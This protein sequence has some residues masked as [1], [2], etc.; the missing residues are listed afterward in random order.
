MNGVRSTF[1]RKGYLLT[2]LAAAALLAASPGTAVA[3]TTGVTIMGPAMDTINE[4]GTA[5]YTVSISGYVGVATNDNDPMTTDVNDPAA[6][7]VV[8]G[9]PTAAGTAPATATAGELADLNSNLHVLTVSFDPPANSSYTNRRLFTASQTISVVTL[10]D[11][12]AEN[13]AFDI[14]F[15]PLTGVAQVFTTA[16]T[17]TS[18]PISLPAN[19]PTALIIDDDETQTYTLSLAPNAMPTEG[20][21]L[22][23]TGTAVPAHTSQGSS[24]TLSVYTDPSD[25]YTLTPDPATLTIDGNDP[26][27]TFTITQDLGDENRVADTVTVSAYRT[28]PGP[29]ADTLV[30]SLPITFADANALPAVTVEF[31]N[32]NGSIVLDPQPTSVAEGESVHVRATAV[33]AMGNATAPA[34][35]LTIQLRAGASGTADARDIVAPGALTIGTDATNSTSATQSNVVELTIFGP[36]DDVGDEMLV[37][38]AIV[39]GVATNG[40]ET[41]TSSS[42][43]TLTITDN[44]AKQ[45][46]PKATDVAYP[47]ITGA[48]EDGAGDGGLNPGEMVEIMTDELFDVMEGYTASYS[49]SVEGDQVSASASGS[50]VTINALKAGTAHVTITGTATMGSSSLMPS[51]T[52]S[53]VASLTF[54]VEV[55]D[56]PLM[57]TLEMP[58]TVMG[59]RGDVVEGSSHDINVMANRM[60]TEEEGSVEV[61]IMADR[62]ASDARAGED[63]TVGN[64]TIMAGYDSATATLDV[65]EDNMPDA[66]TDDNM[67][68]ALVLYG[69]YGDGMETNDL[70]FTIW[71]AAVPALPLIAQILL[72]LF[73]ALGG[74]RLYRRHQG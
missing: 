15:T 50:M 41:S 16:D 22:T 47:V 40:T 32:E 11:N 9:D 57:I 65:M 4:G 52:V 63:Y 62:S 20:Q 28:T 24:G 55:V 53:N 18:N 25:G 35:Q 2:A 1:M 73:L 74:A 56:K 43:A 71:D 27:D 26:V 29:G 58:D 23:V 61:M 7:N 69:T 38:D 14:A 37:L 13:E 49:V 19:A 46:E 54:P 17:G 21:T 45:I 30:A 64:A 51:Q 10:H 36:D 70:M 68:E 33:N 59:D 39:S 72:A 67:G 66:G 8:L 3:Q 48:I 42:V 44:S 6:F 60:V 34:E 5:T 31:T 12:D